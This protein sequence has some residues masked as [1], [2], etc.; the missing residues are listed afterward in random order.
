MRP[1]QCPGIILA[2]GASTRLGG[3]GD[4]GHGGQAKQLLVFEGK[5]LLRRAAEAAV[6][7]AGERTP[8]HV[9][10]GHR[11]EECAAELAGFPVGVVTPVRAERWAVGMGASLKAGLRAALNRTPDARAVV[12][13]LCDQP[14]V[15][16]EDLRRFRV[17]YAATDTLR[18]PSRRPTLVA[19]QYGGSLGV[20]VLF[21]KETFEEVLA[22]DD[23]AG[24]KPLIQRHAAAG[25]AGAFPLPAAGVDVDTPEDFARLTAAEATGKR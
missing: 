3:G 20:P 5:T 17:A 16:A 12:V 24:A 8:V 1:E 18:G 19:A 25:S 10:L 2:A 4:H 22:L 6:A 9:V 13:S 21:A 23:A 11:A 15:R 7:A 14:L